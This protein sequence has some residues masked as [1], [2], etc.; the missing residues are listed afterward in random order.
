[1]GVELLVAAPRPLG[2]VLARLAADGCQVIMIDGALTLPGA[3]PPEGWREVRLRTPAGTVTLGRGPGG[4]AV[5]VFGNA[6][7]LLL[8]AQRRIADALA[9][10]EG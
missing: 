4:V 8:A 5:R 7:P 2:P 10:P 3:I 1:M 6:S 9:E